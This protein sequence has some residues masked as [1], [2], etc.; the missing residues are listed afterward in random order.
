M[1]TVT[2]FE[3]R[4]KKFAFLFCLLGSQ[5]PMVK[6]GGQFNE[7]ILANWPVLMEMV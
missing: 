3:K 5:Y 4:G 1:K 2:F 6:G 7:N